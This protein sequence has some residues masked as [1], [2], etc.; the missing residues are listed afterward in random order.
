MGYYVIIS[1]LNNYHSYLKF[2]LALSLGMIIVSAALE[3]SALVVMFSMISRSTEGYK[4][5]R[6]MRTFFGLEACFLYCMIIGVVL[7]VMAESG[8]FAHYTG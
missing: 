6:F 5:A 2:N 4:E 1:F 3:F 7:T 8:L